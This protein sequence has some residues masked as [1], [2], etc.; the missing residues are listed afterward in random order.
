MG[1]PIGKSTSGGEV[2]H[3]TSDPMCKRRVEADRVAFGGNLT[4]QPYNKQAS[5]YMGKGE[6][7][8]RNSINKI[9]RKSLGRASERCKEFCGWTIV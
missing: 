1:G 5:I 9:R 7:G 4:G 3:I 6:L 8:W 2:T